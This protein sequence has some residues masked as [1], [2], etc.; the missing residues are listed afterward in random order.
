MI[1][2]GIVVLMVTKVVDANT[3]VPIITAV[4]AYAVGSAKGAA[5]TMQ[6]AR[7]AAAAMPDRSTK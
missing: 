1:F 3:G 7:I 5:T 6:V 2:I 4:L